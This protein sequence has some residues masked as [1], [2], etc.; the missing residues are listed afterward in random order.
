MDKTEL[1]ARMANDIFCT[2]I[3]QIKL[4]AGGDTCDIYR[5]ETMCVELAGNILR[6]SIDVIR[7]EDE[8]ENE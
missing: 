4:W 6:Q 2:Q 3:S 1:L 7:A 5:L 8:S